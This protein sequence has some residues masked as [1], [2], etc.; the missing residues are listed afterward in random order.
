MAGFWTVLLR[1]LYHQGASMI[2]LCCVGAQCDVC[3]PGEM[4]AIL[5]CLV[6]HR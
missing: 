3:L 4:I 6:C 5:C 2:C 1:G